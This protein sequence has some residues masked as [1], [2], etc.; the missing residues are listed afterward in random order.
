MNLSKVLS[1]RLDIDS[2]SILDRLARE[3]G[4]SKGSVIRMIIREMNR[5]DLNSGFRTAFYS[6]QKPENTFLEDRNLR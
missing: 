4:R 2:Y 3:S 5:G 6:R 1:I